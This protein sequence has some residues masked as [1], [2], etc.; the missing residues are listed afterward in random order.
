MIGR[1]EGGGHLMTVTEHGGHSDGAGDSLWARTDVLY[2]ELADGGMIYDSSS[3]QVHHLNETAALVWRAC[4][5]GA[6]IAEVIDELCARYSV[7]EQTATKDAHTAVQY[8]SA[9]GLLI[10]S[11]TASKVPPS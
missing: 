4:Q 8:L 2:R 5:R 9:G 7:D 11:A 3:K 10:P 1:R 6:P